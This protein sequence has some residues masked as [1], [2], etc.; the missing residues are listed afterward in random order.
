M[1]SK[2]KVTNDIECTITVTGK[3]H[4][5]MQ[6]EISQIKVAEELCNWKKNARGKKQNKKNNR[7]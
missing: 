3:Q 6:Q 2:I 5:R 1:I 4:I 7:I